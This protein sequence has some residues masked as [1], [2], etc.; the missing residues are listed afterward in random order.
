[1]PPPLSPP[2]PPL[3]RHSPAP[4][5]QSE[6]TGERR[7]GQACYP[8]SI[9]VVVRAPVAAP[10]AARARARLLGPRTARETTGGRCGSH[11]RTLPGGRQARAAVATLEAIAS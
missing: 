7:G 11:I 8:K 5:V 3:Y 4:L 2:S 1:M 9:R 10:V 6:E